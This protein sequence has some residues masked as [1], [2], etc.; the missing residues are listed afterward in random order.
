VAGCGRQTVPDYDGKEGRVLTDALQELRDG[1][2]KRS[3]TAL[4]KLA[5]VNP[6]SR[7]PD[8]AL[9]HERDRELVVRLNRHLQ[10]GELE[11]AGEI[12]R[13]QRRYGDMGTS[14]MSWSELPDALRAMERYITEKPYATSAKM[15]QALARVDEYRELLDHSPAFLAFRAAE[16][17]ELGQFV[18]R[19]RERITWSLLCDLDALVLVGDPRAEQVLAEIVATV[20]KDHPLP[21]TVAAVALGDWRKVRELSE[22]DPAGLYQSEYLEIAFAMSWDELSNDVR[23]ALGRGLVRL[24]PCTLSGL[25][26]HSRYAAYYGRMDD[27][28]IYLRELSSSVQM[29]PQLVGQVLDSLV[30]PQSSFRAP[31]WQR[32]VPGVTDFLG[33]MDQ[34]RDR[35]RASENRP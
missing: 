32:P 28:V 12:L 34:L 13:Y 30:L 6:D 22:A 9:A 8:L 20:G 27:A 29:T 31:C 16:D 14:L 5:E 3:L 17:T 33:R 18:V 2:P 35:V 10:A 19:E 11:K 26:L 21:A 7:L 1:D 25:L 23:R 4:Q 24:P 15:R